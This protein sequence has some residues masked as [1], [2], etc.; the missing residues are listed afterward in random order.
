MAVHTVT[1]AQKFMRKSRGHFVF[2]QSASYRRFFQRLVK[3]A[4]V[5]WNCWNTPPLGNAGNYWTLAAPRLSRAK[6]GFKAF[7]HL[8]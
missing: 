7:A 8:A 2:V 5:N 4:N 6:I 3:R 1:V